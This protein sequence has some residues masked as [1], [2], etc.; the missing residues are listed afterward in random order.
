MIGRFGSVHCFKRIEMNRGDHHKIIQTI[1]CKYIENHSQ[2]KVS[3]IFAHKMLNGMVSYI[4]ADLT[5]SGNI[6]AL[7]EESKLRPGAYTPN[8]TGVICNDVFFDFI[9]FPDLRNFTQFA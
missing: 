1:L 9:V 6:K 8:H 3:H 7:S 2:I 4:L 5:G